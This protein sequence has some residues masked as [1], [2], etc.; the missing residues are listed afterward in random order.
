MFCEVPSVEDRAMSLPRMRPMLE[1]IALKH[2]SLYRTVSAERAW[3]SVGNCD[4]HSGQ[5][6]LIEAALNAG[7][8]VESPSNGNVSRRLS[9]SDKGYQAI[10]QQR[11]FW[12]E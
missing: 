9:L 4:N 3:F 5:S 2:R 6:I 7:F 11:P 1:A 8:V 10:N 12:M